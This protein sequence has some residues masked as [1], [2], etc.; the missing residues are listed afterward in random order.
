MYG[1]RISCNKN[2]EIS[3]TN[4]RNASAEWFIVQD[5]DG[6]YKLMNCVQSKFLH[7]NVNDYQIQASNSDPSKWT[8]QKTQG[9]T[10]SFTF[11]ESTSKRHLL[12]HSDLWSSPSTI[13]HRDGG[14]S[15]MAYRIL[16]G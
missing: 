13:R 14:C 3:S 6:T 7:L 12:M 11:C 4:N 16:I 15:K 8:I 9:G 5:S 10:A 1:K 2:G